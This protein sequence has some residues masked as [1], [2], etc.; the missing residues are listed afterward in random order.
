MPTNVFGGSYRAMWSVITVRAIGTKS[1]TIYKIIKLASVEE[2]LPQGEVL[3]VLGRRSLERRTG[4]QHTGWREGG[5]AGRTLQQRAVDDVLCHQLADCGLR[6]VEVLSPALIPCLPYVVQ[7]AETDVVEPVRDGARDKR[8]FRAVAL[9][10]Q[11]ARRDVREF[12]RRCGRCSSAT[13]RA[14]FAC[15]PLDDLT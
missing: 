15:V 12:D 13:R 9:H 2:Y 8:G 3:K 10:P 6:G 11:E 4:A 7:H 14:S 5:L 1:E